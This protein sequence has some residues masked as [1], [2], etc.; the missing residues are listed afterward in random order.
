MTHDVKGHCA[1]LCQP[2]LSFWLSQTEN[3]IVCERAK[4]TSSVQGSS[5]APAPFPLAHKTREKQRSGGEEEE[6]KKKEEESV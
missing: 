3:D 4:S 5:R 2:R 1:Q 6:G